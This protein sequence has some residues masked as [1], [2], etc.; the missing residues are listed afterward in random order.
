MKIGKKHKHIKAKYHATKQPVSHQT[1]QEK[2]KKL[3]NKW[4][5]KYNVPKI[6]EMQQKHF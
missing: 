6:C 4:K 1:N 5:W 3:C 2:I